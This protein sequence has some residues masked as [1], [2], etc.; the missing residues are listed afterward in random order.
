ML[1]W[2]NYLY[3]LLSV[4]LDLTLMLYAGLSSIFTKTDSDNR[5]MYLVGITNSD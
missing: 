3:I 4:I 5:Y 1:C 2:L